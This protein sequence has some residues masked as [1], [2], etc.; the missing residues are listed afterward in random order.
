M[1]LR[2]AVIV[3]FGVLA[4]GCLFAQPP[5]QNGGISPSNTM[6]S[7]AVLGMFGLTVQGAVW[8]STDVYGER[9]LHTSP[10]VGTKGV[11][12]INRDGTYDWNSAWDDRLIHG[13][14]T[15]GPDGIVL[16]D[17]QEHKNWSVAPRNKPG[18]ATI[19]VFDNKYMVYDG[20]PIR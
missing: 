8:Q 6:K 11:L 5:Q 15:T 13:R 4:A 18:K 1:F 16:V 19:F 20:T 2:S 17:A 10:P 7:P 14:W 9:W 3:L 12:K